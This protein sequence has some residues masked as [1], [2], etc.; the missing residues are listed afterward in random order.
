MRC[1]DTRSERTGR[2][3]SIWLAVTAVRIPISALH[4]D[5]RRPLRLSG[6][7][8]LP[9]TAW[10]RGFAWPGLSVGLA[11][12]RPRR[13]VWP[14]HRRRRRPSASARAYPA[15]HDRL[16]SR[17]RFSCTLDSPAFR[18]REGKFRELFARSL[19][20]VERM[21]ARSARQ[22]F[23]E[24]YPPRNSLPLRSTLS[25][26]TSPTLYPTKATSDSIS[27][28]IARLEAMIT[29]ARYGR[30]TRP[31]PQRAIAMT[32]LFVVTIPTA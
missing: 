9:S 27:S 24:F 8:R 25:L 32:V 11:R 26:T 15:F 28:Q 5:L 3:P 6:A 16:A 18:I 17:S 12:C 19:S 10:P 14:G 2:C 13:V 4:E 1:D 30:T 21:D 31:R 29:I 20:E 7:G 23:P 22:I